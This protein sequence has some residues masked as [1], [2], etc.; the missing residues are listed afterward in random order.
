LALDKLAGDVRK[1]KQSTVNILRQGMHVFD[2]K[3][4][5][6]GMV[7]VDCNAGGGSGGKQQLMSVMLESCSFG[8]KRGRCSGPSGRRGIHADFSK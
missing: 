5:G 1:G 7:V 4:M 6:N 3:E 8:K 2:M